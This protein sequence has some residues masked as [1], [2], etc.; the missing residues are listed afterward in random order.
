MPQSYTCDDDYKVTS[1]KRTVRLRQ[2]PRTGLVF[3]VTYANNWEAT[4]A[5]KE[6]GFGW[7]IGSQFFFSGRNVVRVM[8]F[9]GL[10]DCR[11]RSLMEEMGRARGEDR[12]RAE[13]QIVEE[14][15]KS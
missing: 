6:F 11:L 8:D 13:D 1:I 15:K 4:Q 10:P 14:W 7:V 2:W 9:L 5:K 3:S 12:R